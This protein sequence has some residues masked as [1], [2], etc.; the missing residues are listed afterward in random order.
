MAGATVQSAYS[1]DDSGGTATTASIALTSVTAGNL[2]ASFVGWSDGAGTIT[3]TVSDGTAYTSGASKLTGGTDAQ[4]SQVFYLPNAGSGTHT[5]VATF[6]STT[7]FRR[8][9]IDEYSGLAT[10]SPIDQATGQQQNTPGTGADAISSGTTST[11]ANANCFV[12]GYTQNTTEIDPGTGT[13]TA[14]SGYTIFGTNK[15]M[16][17][18]TK[19][20]S[21]TGAQT[22]TFTQSVNNS[23]TTH[24]IAFKEAATAPTINTQ[25]T[26]QQGPE[27]GSA[28]FTVAATTSGGSLSYQW[29]L[30][31]GG[32]FANVGTN[33]ATYT[34][35]PLRP[36]DAGSVKC[37]VT[38]SNGTTTTRTV[39]LSVIPYDKTV[40]QRRKRRKKG[41]GRLINV[42]AW[43]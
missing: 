12:V 19:S 25:P 2:L 6:S 22:A 37:D 16:G 27:F 41:I 26:N 43:M 28:T 17:V 39:T 11:T 10:A 20:V 23:H 5:S 32:G 7:T 40:L 14:G 38:D 34:P 36:I 15:I 1:V 29:K 18:E 31:T 9:R 42:K 4:A 13:L 33:A 21:A 30:D 3:C 35:S 24:V 8:H